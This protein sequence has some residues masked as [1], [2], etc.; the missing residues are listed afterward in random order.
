MFYI[1][2]LHSGKDGGLYTGFTPDLRSRLKAHQNG[3]VFST[4]S[5]LPMTLIHYE[6]FTHESDA[7]Q[8]KSYLKGGNGKKDIEKM[9]EDYFHNNPWNKNLV[10]EVA[11]RPE[12]AITCPICKGAKVAPTKSF[13]TKSGKRTSGLSAICITCKGRGWIIPTNL[14]ENC[15]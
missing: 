2:I 10:E 12:N 3:F 6:A 15:K 9:L 13:F 1:Y 8:R 14:S 11:E 4:K 5:R 7:K